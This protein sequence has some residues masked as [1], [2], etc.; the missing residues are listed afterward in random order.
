MDL[1]SLL[2]AARRRVDD[3]AIRRLV[4]VSREP[5]LISFGGGMPSADAF[6]SGL[7]EIAHRA[8]DERAPRALQYGPTEGT[9]K[10][11]AQ[12]VE[13]L[14]R[15]EGIDATAANILVTTSSQQALDLISR[16]FVDPGDPVVVELPSYIGG[17]QALQ[18]CGADLMGVETDGDGIDVDALEARLAGLSAEGRRCKLLYVIPDSQ[19]P[20]G[21]TLSAPRRRT[22]TE[23]AERFGVLV[24]E[25][26]PYRQVRF[27]G[28][29]PPMLYRTVTTGNVVSVFTFSKTLAPGLRLG[30]ILAHEDI[31]RELAV[32]KQPLDMGTSP[33]IQILASEFLKAGLLP[34]H[35]TGIRKLYARKRDLMLEALE[36]HM[37]PGVSWTR[38]SGGLF[39]WVR[40]PDSVDADE[41][42]GYAVREKV[43][44]IPGSAFHCDGSG[45]NTLRL[46]F[47]FPEEERIEVG[48]ER[49]ARVVRRALTPA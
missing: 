15:E 22:L 42:L 12:I 36:R 37:P 10:L 2:S 30:F 9:S 47:S 49:L 21:V 39:L 18:A 14:R 48:I 28:D 6:P 17:L 26:A 5:G 34:A 29:A 23:L 33:L 46:N 11:K 32:L 20:T 45:R 24:V 38:P 41:L 43:A 3:S 16:T 7:G 4:E 13:L 27:E 35:L 31:I 8:I 1:A 40:L 44:F 25:D 19:N